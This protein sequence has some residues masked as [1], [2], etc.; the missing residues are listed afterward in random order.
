[1][2]DSRSAEWSVVFAAVTLKAWDP[3]GPGYTAQLSALVL[4][5]VPAPAAMRG[6]CVTLTGSDRRPD[7]AHNLLLKK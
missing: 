1:M 3:S 2:E 7:L 4:G 5:S 6:F